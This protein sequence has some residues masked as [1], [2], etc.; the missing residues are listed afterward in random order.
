MCTA[1][2]TAVGV[3]IASARR[4]RLCIPGGSLGSGTGLAH[5]G[6]ETPTHSSYSSSP[7][8]GKLLQDCPTG[9]TRKVSNSSSN[10]FGL[11]QALG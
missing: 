7:T 5:A 8:F 10:Q 11:Q 2:N 4:L 1:E 3:P 6:C 9:K